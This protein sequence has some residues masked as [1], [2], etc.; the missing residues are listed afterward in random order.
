M[1]AD[2]LSRSRL[3][4]VEAVQFEVVSDECLSLSL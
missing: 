2:V 4:K 1:L 3:D